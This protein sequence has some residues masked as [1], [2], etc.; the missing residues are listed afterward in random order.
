MSQIKSN[1]YYRKIKSYTTPTNNNQAWLPGP[2]IVIWLNFIAEKINKHKKRTEHWSVATYLKVLKKNSPK[3]YIFFLSYKVFGGCRVFDSV[4]FSLV[5]FWHISKGFYRF[6]V[7]LKS[8]WRFIY[9]CNLLQSAD[10]SVT[11]QV[12]LAYDHEKANL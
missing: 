4:R 5:F 1:K 11:R 2:K 7:Y 12:T 10:A 6:A 8:S 9:W 3:M